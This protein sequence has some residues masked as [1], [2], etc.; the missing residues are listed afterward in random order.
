LSSPRFNNPNHH[1]QF[2]FWLSPRPRHGNCCVCVCFLPFPI[3]DDRAGATAAATWP[4]AV[5]S[6]IAVK[7]E[8]SSRVRTL[9]RSFLARAAY[10]FPELGGCGVPLRRKAGRFQHPPPRERP[11]APASPLFQARPAIIGAGMRARNKVPSSPRRRSPTGP[12]A[13]GGV[14]VPRARR[15]RRPGLILPGWMRGHITSADQRTKAWSL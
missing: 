7:R 2:P 6:C 8:C 1:A 11:R 12:A 15:R 13:P 9:M 5:R 14:T 3:V 10:V 4:H